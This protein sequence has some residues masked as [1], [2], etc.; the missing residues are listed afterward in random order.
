MEIKDRNTEYQN[1]RRL[2]VE[3]IEYNENGEIESIL[4]TVKRDEG[5][6]YEEGTV[7]NAKTLT[8]IGKKYYVENTKI[9]VIADGSSASYGSIMIEVL[10]AVEVEIENEYQD[11][12]SVNYQKYGETIKIEVFAG[13]EP[14]GD[15]ALEYDFNV[16]LTSEE[17]GVRVGKIKCK[18]EYYTPSTN[19]ED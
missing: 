4:V 13:K 17:T 14:E 19:P 11:L 5:K 9:K 7:L 8:L 1:R 6:V 12:F 18:V 15:G 3:E 16:V 2:E 10:E